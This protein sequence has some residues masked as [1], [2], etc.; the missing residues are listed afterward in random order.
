MVSLHSTEYPAQYWWYPSTVLKVSC[1]VLMVSLHSTG[2]YPFTVMMVSPTVAN[3]LQW[4]VVSQTVIMVYIP[5]PYTKHLESTAQAFPRVKMACFLKDFVGNIKCCM[6]P[7]WVLFWSSPGKESKRF[8]K[9]GSHSAMWV[10]LF[11]FI[12]TSKFCQ[13]KLGYWGQEITIHRPLEGISNWGT[14]LGIE[15]HNI[16]IISV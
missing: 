14:M 6:C 12:R 15:L 13:V 8:R 4:L 11:I 3:T 2:C 10:H 7:G 9:S 1:T 5:P 16:C